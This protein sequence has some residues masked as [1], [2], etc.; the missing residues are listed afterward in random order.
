MCRAGA[1]GDERDRPADAIPP[2]H[3]RVERRCEL[4]GPI[5]DE[6]PKPSGTFA[7]V[8]DEVAGLLGGPGP[9]GMSGHAQDVHVAVAASSANKT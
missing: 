1:K 5:A 9:V 4:T 2:H 3:D 7:E 8:H 6:E